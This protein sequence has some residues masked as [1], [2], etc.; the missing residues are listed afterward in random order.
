[1]KARLKGKLILGSLVMALPAYA[2]GM[3]ELTHQVNNLWQLMATAL[4]FVMHLGFA[5][6]EAGLTRAKNTVNILFKNV[7]VLALGLLTYTLC[8][9]S[10]MFPGF[11]AGAGEWFG[12]RGW[13]PGLGGADVLEPL[14][15][16]SPW[17]F[18]LFQG[19][20]AA[21][22]ATIVSGAVAERI[23]LSAF[24]LFSTLFVAFVYPV[25]GSWTWGQGWLH[26]KG[27]HD[28]AGSTLV[29]SVGGW[30]ALAG[31]LVLGPRLGKYVNSTVKPI[32]GHNL[33]LS[34]I[35]VMLLWF[36]WY[37]FNGG[38]VLNADTEQIA[39]VFV[40]TSL[41]ASSGLI[42][43]MLCSW[44][45]QRKPDL[46]MTLNGALA[47]LVGITAGADILPIKAA[48]LIGFISGILV[49]FCI[50]GFDKLRIDDPVG[51]LSVHLVGGVW[52]TL[53]VGYFSDAHSLGVQAL[54]V[55][56]YG[57]GAFLP[58][59]L[60]FWI[61]RLTMGLRVSEDEELGG[62][63]IGEH[64]MEAYNGFQIFTTQ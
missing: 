10:L 11:E 17:S 56:A 50:S 49:V 29:H 4:V 44:T 8:G 14:R 62:L 9:Y 24:L 58:A 34:T 1:M 19:M 46:T 13:G 22:C 12:F 61:L 40:M 3:D 7:S 28:F 39:R 35:G 63:D 33:P 27:F 42:S 15:D 5:T 43:A 25:L 48:I 21:T 54:G 30:A 38:S 64:G 53:A 52:G 59:L 20:F 57:L 6:L 32:I 18:F 47:G 55:A 41:S 23:K 16:V 45:V 36:G 51:A 2:E 37:G 31:A 60:L 26:D